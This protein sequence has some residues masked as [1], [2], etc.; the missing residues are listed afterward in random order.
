MRDAITQLQAY[1]PRLGLG[2]GR[3]GVGNGL[4]VYLQAVEPRAVS[5][6]HSPIGA[7]LVCH[8]LTLHDGVGYVDGVGGVAHK[9]SHGGGDAQSVHFDHGAHPPLC[10]YLGLGLCALI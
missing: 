4:G 1:A 5:A 10:T 8:L 7:I 6:Y 9:H 2:L 3:E